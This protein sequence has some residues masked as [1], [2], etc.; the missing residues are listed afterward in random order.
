MGNLL[1]AEF[2]KLSRRWSFWG[3]LLISITL[4]SALLIDGLNRVSGMWRAS[5]FI[6]P[7]LYFLCIVFSALFVGEEFE[8]RTLHCLVSAGHGRGHILLA[9]MLAYQTA[10]VV[11]VTA[12]L[13]L[14]TMIGTALGS[15]IPAELLQNLYFV[16]TAALA[17]G[18]LPFLIAVFLR[19]VGK[20]IAVSLTAFGLMLFALNGS[21]RVLASTILPVGH[22]RLL[23]EGNSPVS[24]TALAGIDAIWLL[25]AYAAAYLSFFR[26][27]LK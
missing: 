26:S 23:A 22:L 24:F 13:L 9:K 3:T 16:L 19:S 6:S 11:F 20:T 25:A 18:I 1:K 14:H 27:D 15:G 7:N 21:H 5:L 12:P 17:M 4:S 10:A 2:Y 8:N